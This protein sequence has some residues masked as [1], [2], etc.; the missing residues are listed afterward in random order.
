MKNRIGNLVIMGSLLI[1]VFCL[2]S[3]GRAQQPENLETP[4]P[5]VI[6][7]PTMTPEPEITPEPTPIPKTAKKT[8]EECFRGW[9]DDKTPEE[10]QA[11]YYKKELDQVRYDNL[12]DWKDAKGN[13][14]APKGYLINF[15]FSMHGVEIMASQ[16]MPPKLLKE[17]NTE[18]LYQLIMDLPVD[19]RYPGWDTAIMDS[20]L[21]LLSRYYIAYNFMTD[22]MRRKDA[23]K[24][25][26]HYY[27]KYS[28][29][30]RKKYSLDIN[31]DYFPD[32]AP[33]REEEWTKAERF[34][35]TEGL[36]WLFLYKEGKK[37]PDERLLGLGIGANY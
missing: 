34:R 9:L 10:I 19:E 22:F 17:I 23:P 1:I 8:L 2:L 28:K 31:Y 14:H 35:I 20:Y 16:Q 3:C 15:D 33:D 4:E 37:V 26:H 36:E 29:K 13:Y 32:D 6:A 11:E 30:E 7:E 12:A 25:V 18:E 21:Q 24:V 27:Q 5:T